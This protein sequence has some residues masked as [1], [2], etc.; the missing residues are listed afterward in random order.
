M[1][2]V[3][4]A[5]SVAKAFGGRRILTGAWLEA[6]AGAVTALIGRN[7]TGKTTL[8]KIAAGWL[9]ADRGFVEF[10]G[11]RHFAPRPARLARDGLFYLPMDRSIL[12]PAFTL[13]QHLDAVERRFGVDGRAE[14][15][16]RLGLARVCHVPCRALSGGEHRRAELAVALLRRP[17]CLLADEP[18]RGIPPH[19]ADAILRAFREMADAG[20]A[21]VVTGHETGWVLQAADEV[22]WMRD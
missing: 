9:R 14:V 4:W 18:F 22:L 8:L 12:S 17:A 3:L 5:D 15:L 11:M 6:H 2:A 19:D 16:E 1:T 7:G 13:G 20:C 21:V 10:R